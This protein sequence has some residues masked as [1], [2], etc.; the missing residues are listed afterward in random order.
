MVAFK[1]SSSMK[2]YAPK[3]P[4]KR[5]VKLWVLSNAVTGYVSEFNIYTGKVPGECEFGLGLRWQCGKEANTQCKWS[6]ACYLL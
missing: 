3:R 2:Q 5:G 1:G 4:V 6:P